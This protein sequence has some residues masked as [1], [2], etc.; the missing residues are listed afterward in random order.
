MSTLFSDVSLK[1][2]HISSVISGE[3][4]DMR[5]YCLFFFTLKKYVYMITGNILETIN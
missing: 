1:K 2:D 5:E 3:K 4:K